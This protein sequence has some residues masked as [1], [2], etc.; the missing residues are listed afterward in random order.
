MLSL[1]SVRSRRTQQLVVTRDPDESCANT[2]STFTTTTTLNKT[3]RSPEQ[4][5]STV[6]DAPDRTNFITSS[7]KSRSKHLPPFPQS[8][9]SWIGAG[10]NSETLN[11]GS[12]AIHYL[13]D[14]L[15]ASGD[16]TSTAYV[17]QCSVHSKVILGEIT[18]IV[19]LNLELMNH[20]TKDRSKVNDLMQSVSDQLKSIAY[21]RIL[22]G[23]EIPLGTILLSFLSLVVMV[24]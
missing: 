14:I 5:L 7:P 20:F 17:P 4:A 6:V 13:R 8:S 15:K 24:M 19:H 21:T 22:T 2:L 11:H 3:I 12:C 16:S 1:T 9:V 18:T 23:M 10:S